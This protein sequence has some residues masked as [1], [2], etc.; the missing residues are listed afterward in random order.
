MWCC[1]LVRIDPKV[2]N[3]DSQ[4]VS[5]LVKDH[6]VSFGISV[7]YA[8]TNLV[9]QRSLWNN[10]S[11]IQNKYKLPWYLLVIL[12]AFLVLMNTEV[13][14][15]MLVLQWMISASGLMI[16]CFFIFLHLE[17]FSLGVMAEEE[18]CTLNKGLIYPYAIN[19]G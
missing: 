5:F 9:I 7:V 17:C 6:D 19:C 2:I 14:T 15:S 11:L 13:N 16:I 10:M 12:I 18:L 3:S 1:C 8:S 4:Q